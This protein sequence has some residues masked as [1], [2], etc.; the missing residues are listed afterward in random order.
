M[1]ADAEELQGENVH[2]RIPKEPCDRGSET[3]VPPRLN[4]GR[5]C[6][7]PVIGEQQ[8]LGFLAIHCSMAAFSYDTPSAATTGC[9]MTSY[10]Q[11][12]GA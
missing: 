7:A 1:C 12:P 3:G 4:F 5:L 6:G 11:R 9:R 10:T 2:S 8:I